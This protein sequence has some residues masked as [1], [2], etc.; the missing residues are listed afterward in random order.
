MFILCKRPE[1]KFF[2]KLGPFNR[3]MYNVN[4]TTLLISVYLSTDCLKSHRFLPDY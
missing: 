2:N 4:N 3:P 1:L